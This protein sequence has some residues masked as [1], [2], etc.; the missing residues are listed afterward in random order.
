M[1]EKPYAIALMSAGLDSSL[2][3][4]LIVDQG[5]SVKALHF[6]STF[7]NAKSI[8]TSKTI[9]KRICEKLGV[10]L[11]CVELTDDYINM[12]KAP[13]FGYGSAVN[14][15]IDCRIFMLKKAR[16]HMESVGAECIIT[17]EVL[18]QRPMSQHRAQIQLIEKESGLEGRILR[19]LS[20]KHFLP[21]TAEKEGIIDRTKLLKIE[22]RSRKEQLAFAKTLGIDEFIPAAGGCLLCDT[23]FEKKLR[24]YFEHHLTI[25]LDEIELLKYGRHL[26]ISENVKLIVGRN[27]TENK[28]LENHAKNKMTCEVV[29]I[30][31]P[32]TVIEGDPSS[33]ELLLAARITAA[34][35][36][37][38]EEQTV[39]VRCENKELTVTPLDIK[40]VHSYLLYT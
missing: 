33:D 19:P 16:E 27:E 14:P 12:I 28:W 13:K 23:Q 8:E 35:S 37:A 31:S 5:V 40:E 36:D 32:T 15:C 17:G 24:D 11:V 2:A 34:Y 7:F 10:G 4:K 21:T 30:P 3:V 1:K 20:A 9:V 18:G 22:G 26:R 38:K 39:R 29:D 25:S 6:V